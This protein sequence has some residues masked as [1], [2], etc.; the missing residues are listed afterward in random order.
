[1]K[2]ITTGT[3]FRPNQIGQPYHSLVL[4]IGYAISD[5][6]L[7]TTNIEELVHSPLLG[8]SLKWGRANIGLKAGVD[9]KERFNKAYIIDDGGLDSI[10]AKNIPGNSF[11]KNTDF[12]FKLSFIYETDVNWLYN[13]FAAFYKLTASPIFTFEY[14]MAINRYDYTLSVSPQPYDSYLFNMKLTLDLHKN[15]QGGL[16]SRFALEQ[17]R[18]WLTTGISREVFSY[19]IGLNFTL[20][21]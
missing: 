19:E 7:I 11:F 12:G 4:D 20:L 16:Q 13:L 14:I 21:F 8:F 5:N 2:L 9:Y 18:S 15:I 10:Y 17:Y 6:M 3:F 1:M